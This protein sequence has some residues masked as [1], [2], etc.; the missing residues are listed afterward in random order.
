MDKPTTDPT[1]TPRQVTERTLATLGFSNI[2]HADLMG[3]LDTAVTA[4]YDEAN[5]F[6]RDARTHVKAA[7]ATRDIEASLD[8]LAAV[9]RAAVP[10][11]PAFYTDDMERWAQAVEFAGMPEDSSNGLES[12]AYEIADAMAH[13][14]DNPLPKDQTDLERV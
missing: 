12:W 1:L 10:H 7:Q 13:I 11:V 3:F 4:T 2:G 14:G 6:I 9:I 8:R 5:D